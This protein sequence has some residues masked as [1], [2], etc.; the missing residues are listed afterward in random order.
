[1]PTVSDAEGEQPDGPESKSEQPQTIEWL[2]GEMGNAQALYQEI[3]RM[4]DPLVIAT[5]KRV[6]EIAANSTQSALSSLVEQTLRDV[7]AMEIPNLHPVAI[8]Q[9]TN[10]TTTLV[11]DL[12]A[13]VAELGEA[14]TKYSLPMPSPNLARWLD[15]GRDGMELPEDATLPTEEEVETFWMSVT[16]VVCILMS[17]FTLAVRTGNWDAASGLLAVLGAVGGLYAGVDKIMKKV[18]K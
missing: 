14:L 12:N 10:F 8:L 5:I 16:I 2:L 4:M 15:V 7:A 17:V 3:G 13:R 6:Q 11:R 1:M 9:T 18:M